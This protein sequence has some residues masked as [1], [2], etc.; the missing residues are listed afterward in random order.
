MSKHKAL[1]KWQL[2]ALAD[3]SGATLRRWLLD[4]ESELIAAYGYKRYDKILSPG[5]VKF[6]CDK[7]VIV[8][9]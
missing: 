6:L 4:C 5:I 8:L 3:I 2:A 9:E 1:Y 7:Y